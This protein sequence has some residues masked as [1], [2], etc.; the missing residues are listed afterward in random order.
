MSFPCCYCHQI[1]D[2]TTSLP[3]TV[4]Q[5]LVRILKPSCTKCH[6]TT[7]AAQYRLHKNTQ[8]GH[9]EASS[10]SQITA[11]HILQRPMTVPTLPIEKQVAEYLVQQLMTE[12]EDTVIR[13]PKRGQL[14]N[15][16]KV[17]L[18]F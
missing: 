18:Y 13:I 3:S 15:R 17:L 8:Q 7:I 6:K 16:Q 14:R 11:Q 2:L 5:D 12:S 9:Y 4:V 1:D 10:P